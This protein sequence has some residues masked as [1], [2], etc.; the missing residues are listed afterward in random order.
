MDP[1]TRAPDVGRIFAVIGALCALA[2]VPVPAVARPVVHVADVP[3]LYDAVHNPANVGALVVLAAGRYVLDPGER[4]GG[5]LE[6][7]QDMALRGEDGDPRRVVIDASALPSA[8]YAAPPI[9]TGAVRLGRGSNAVEWLTVE[10]AV[11]GASAI[12]TDLVA[13]GR[14]QVRVA[15]VVLRGNVRGVDVRNVGPVHA[16]RVLEVDLVGNAFVDHGVGAGQGLRFA[17]VDAAGAR[18]VATL[19]GN[20]ATGNV[21]GCIAA[22]INTSDAR[23]DIVSWADRFD[24][25]GNGCVLLGGSSGTG[26]ASPPTGNAIVLEAWGGSFSDNVGRLPAAFPIPGGILAVGGQS[27]G[28][29]NAASGNRVVV[30][31][32]GVKLV[33]NREVDVNAIGAYTV[34][35]PAVGADNAVRVELSGVSRQARTLASPSVPADPAGTNTVTVVR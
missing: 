12:A 18:I 30:D 28:G 15:H 4:N 25:N 1:N 24:G 35:G 33:G 26:A 17:N 14:T 22:N 20:R 31:L 16:G 2:S 21:A 32:H 13:H 7:L 23:I 19:H 34:A 3:A 11:L 29:T 8:S 27:A 5:R 9:A 6:L 10:G